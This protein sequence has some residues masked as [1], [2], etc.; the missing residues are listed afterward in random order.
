[1]LTAQLS[2]MFI[3]CVFL[4]YFMFLKIPFYENNENGNQCMQ[5]AM[6]SVIKYF[7]IK[8]FLWMN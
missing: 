2:E 3:N 8:I 1:M 4:L 7:L 5:V 6:K